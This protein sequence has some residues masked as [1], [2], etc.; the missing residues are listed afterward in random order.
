MNGARYSLNQVS[1][2]LLVGGLAT[3]LRPITETIPKALIEVAGKPFI[4]HQLALL[5]RNGIVRVV[6]CV[7]YRGEQIEAWLGDGRELGMELR[8]SYDGEHLL[9]TGG[10]LRK[11]A[12]LV[13]EL[14]WVMYGDSYLDIDYAAVFAHFTRGHHLG[15]MTVFRNQGQWDRSN[16]VY[17]DGRILRYDKKVQ[18]PD[19][20]YIDYGLSLLRREALERIP[21]GQPYD[22]ADLYT[23]LVAEEQMAAYEVH[24][25]F[26][27]IGSPEGLEETRG[28]LAQRGLH[29]R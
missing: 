13:G 21:E 29:K 23:A 26:Y 5:K 20:L 28:Y 24:R 9:G 11:A 3:R 19:M 17:R 1:L 25:R 27:E 8:Y 6:L 22:L 2:A 18:S 14:F 7:G 15:L 12:L 4:E 10:A 16:I